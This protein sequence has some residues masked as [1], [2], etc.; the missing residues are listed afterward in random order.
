MHSIY[1]DVLAASREVCRGMDSHIFALQAKAVHQI[2]HDEKKRRQAVRK[3]LKNEL[4][5]L[6]SLSRSLK[7]GGMLQERVD[8]FLL[9]FSLLG[10]GF[11]STL[12]DHSRGF[13]QQFCIVEF[14]L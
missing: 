11:I 13:D 1:E 10:A 2:R 5:D 12:Y 7:P 3:S 9:Y 4:K 8:N 6:D 14:T